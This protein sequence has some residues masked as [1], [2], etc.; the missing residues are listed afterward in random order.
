MRLKIPILN[1]PTSQLPR[2]TKN[3]NR[4]MQWSGFD[5]SSKEF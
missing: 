5:R 2:S 4:K 1:L 3:G